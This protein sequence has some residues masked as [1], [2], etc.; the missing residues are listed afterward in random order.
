MDQQEVVK[1]LKFIEERLQAHRLRYRNRGQVF[2]SDLETEQRLLR[3][4]RE[5]QKHDWRVK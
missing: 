4:Y 2:E 5:L 3:Q 1:R